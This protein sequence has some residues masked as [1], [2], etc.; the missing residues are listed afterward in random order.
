MS[1]R[2]LGIPRSIRRH[3]AL[4][5]A[6]LVLGAACAPAS[7]I[8][9]VSTTL[10]GG[11]AA[12]PDARTSHVV[13]I[14]VDGLRPD[15][16]GRYGAPT[17]RR[18]ARE[19]RAT[20]NARTIVPSLTLPSHTSMLTGV[21]PD[22]HGIKWNDDQVVGRGLVGVPTVFAVAHAAGLR[23]AAF[24]SKAK[25]R[26]LMLPNSLDYAQAPTGWWGRW[27]AGR[28][29]DDVRDYLRGSARPNLLFVHLGEADYAGHTLGW[30]SW[31]YGRAGRPRRRRGRAGGRV[32][33]RG[34]RARPLHPAPHRRP[35]RPRPHPRHRRLGGR[36]HPLDRLGPGRRHRRFGPAPRR[37]HHGHGSDGALAAWC[38]DT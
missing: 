8:G 36:D 29:T 27:T 38:P 16:I 14:S 15:A 25:F 1:H 6:L 18:L 23:T 20:L 13:V 11:R 28:T 7:R 31:G 35:R 34:V 37:P 9:S 5:I 32:G 26:H 17:I 30:M 21:G 12:L 19:G 2:P 24:F 4:R 22:Q 10:A 3:P 33:R